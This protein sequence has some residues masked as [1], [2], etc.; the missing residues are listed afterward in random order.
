MSAATATA[1]GHEIKQS[2][3]MLTFFGIL[4]VIFG[5]LAVGSPFVA[6]LAVVWYFGVML[7]V[8]GIFRVVYAFKAQSLGAGIWAILIG[9]LT[10]FAGL[11]MLGRPLMSLA[12]MT[13]VLA[14]YFLLEGISQIIYAFQVRPELGWGWALIGGIISLAL[15][16]MIWRAYPAPA[17]WLIG[18]LFGI[19]LLFHGLAMLGIGAAARAVGGEI[20]KMAQEVEEIA[21]IEPMAQKPA[22]ETAAAATESESESKE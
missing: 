17:T 2:A 20:S 14:V 3:G 8:G 19:H 16:F 5:L 6:G 1:V 10:I 22:S 9:F 15:G 4:M 13:L 12:V 21:G 7:V 18:V 11:V